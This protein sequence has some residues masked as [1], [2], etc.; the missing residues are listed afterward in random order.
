MIK[1]VQNWVINIKNVFGVKGAISS[2]IFMLIIIILSVLLTDN[3]PLRFVEGQASKFDL[4]AITETED[5]K[6]TEERIQRVVSGIEPIYRVSPT[7]GIIAKDKILDFFSL[8]RD[9]KFE[10]QT[11]LSDKVNILSTQGSIQLHEDINRT[12]LELE[13]REINY[14]ESIISDIANQ[15]LSQGIRDDDLPIILESLDESV[16]TLNLSDS[17]HSIVV[18]ILKEIIQ[19]NEFI[20]IIATE[21]RI[22]EAKLGVPKSIILPGDIVVRE[23]EIFTEYNIQLLSSAG[24]FEDSTGRFL[25]YYLGII[26]MIV[27]SFSLLITYV[28]KFGKDSIRGNRLYLIYS[29]LGVGILLN[30]LVSIFSNYLMPLSLP[31]ILISILINPMVGILSSI[32][33]IITLLVITNMSLGLG[34]LSIISMSLVFLHLESTNQR[35]QLL[36]KGLYIGISKVILFLSLIGFGISLSSDIIIDS[37]ML[38]SSGII[39][40]ILALG[41]LPIWENVFKILTPQ[42]LMEL[43]NPNEPLLKRLQLEAPGTYQHSLMVGNL[44]E[45]AAERI[46][47]NSLLAKVA[48]YY[49]D[50]GKLKRPKYFKENQLNMNNPH[51]ELE[52]LQSLDIIVSHREDGIKLGK[53]NKL[54]DDIIDI[55]DQHHGTTLMAYFYH[56]ASKEGIELPESKFRYQGTKPQTKEAAIVMLADSVEAAVRSI[57]GIDEEKITSMVTNVIKGKVED[58]QLDESNL[59]LN[60]LKA[61]QD[62][63]VELLKRI[64]H[65][66]I[67]YP[68]LDKS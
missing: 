11:S 38:L 19:E 41:S 43:S 6:A 4:R 30:Y 42:K 39:S 47:A 34:L 61:I 40:G 20:D 27:S 32:F 51:N 36:L 2:L 58:S 22:N 21:R 10:S 68:I 60:E 17:S 35:I 16:A 66:R 65:G 28:I 13:F 1:K 50:I 31:G 26:L 7:V 12:I 64:Y 25:W 44:S 54:H 49:H 14:L 46:G 55:V 45:A 29:I 56:Q 23:G 33:A 67:E 9:V 59:T 15:I 24:V 8:T 5:T 18:S 62:E 57:K 3:A 63:F 53:E 52:T 48:S 37:V